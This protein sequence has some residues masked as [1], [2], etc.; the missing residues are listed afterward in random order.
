MMFPMIIDLS[1]QN[2]DWKVFAASQCATGFFG[3]ALVLT[4]RQESI[5][6]NLK[7]AFLLTNLSWIVI[8]LFGAIPFYYGGANLSLTD[9][10]FESIS[11]ITT[12]GATVIEDLEVL[13][14]GILFWRSILQWLG[15]VGILVMALSILPM[16]QVGGMQLFK[17]ESL[18]MEKVLPSAAKISAYI[19]MLYIIL[20]LVCAVAYSLAGM[21]VF[22]AFSHAMTTIATG[23]YANYNASM[24]HFDSV[25]IDTIAIIFMWL[26]ALPFVLYLRMV[27]G[28]WFCLFSDSQVK[29]FFSIIAA[30]TFLTIS[31]L[32][33]EN[34]WQFLTSLR[35]SLFN[36]TSL[37][38]GTGYA[39]TDYTLWGGFITGLFFFVMCIGGCA[40][41]TSCGIKIFRFQVLYAVTKSQTL[42]MLNPNGVFAAYY[43]KKQIPRDVPIAVMSF[44]FVFA[45]VF[46]VIAVALQFCGLDYLTAMSGAASAVANVGPAMGDI[47]GPAGNYAPLPGNAKWIL[48]AGMLMGRLE[49]FTFL[50]MLSPRFWRR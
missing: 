17:T 39:T 8:G 27:R 4:T 13:D 26:G 28:D 38:T 47:I 23:G 15:G 22:D 24:G 31:F 45:L 49:L 10:V 20:T 25:A 30:I 3:L 18:D 9:A 5:K 11:G 2:E 14:P 36:I 50:V 21:S 16:L 44:F 1:A 32:M 34:D 46:S 43:N 42:K 7:Q 48:C 29:W 19:G 35:Y 40:G 12:T 37:M 6:I 33:I 41:S